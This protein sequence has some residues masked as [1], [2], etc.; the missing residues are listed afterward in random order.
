MREGGTR[1]RVGGE[2]V[3]ESGE[4]EQDDQYTLGAH[5]LSFLPGSNMLIVVSH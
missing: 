2:Y 3:R 1:G 4:R 5:H